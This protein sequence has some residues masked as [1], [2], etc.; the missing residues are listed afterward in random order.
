MDVV[1]NRTATFE[2]S[3]VAVRA[4]ELLHA[5]DYYRDKIKVLSLDCFDTILWRRTATPKDV[6]IDLQQQPT[7]KRLGLTNVMRVKG[8]MHAAQLKKITANHSHATLAEIHRACLLD[9]SEDEI[10]ALGEEEL[11]MEIASCYA[12]SPVV[13]LMRKAHHAGI[14]MIVVSDTYFEKNQLAQLLKSKLPDDVMNMIDAIFCSCEFGSTKTEGMFQPVLQQ[15]K[16]NPSAILHLGDNYN[17]DCIAPKSLGMHALHFSQHDHQVQ[18]IMRMQAVAASFFLQGV[19]NTQP[20]YNPFAGIFAEGVKQGLPEELI[21][22]ASIGPVMYVFA[23]F[24]FAEVE[25]LKQAGKRVKVVFML[26]DGYL[27]SLVCQ[28][29]QHAAFGELIEVSRF[30]AVAASF[31]SEQDVFDY[32]ARAM[33]SLR[34]KDM[35]RQLLLPKNIIESILEKLK[36]ARDPRSVF[37][38]FVKQPAIMKIILDNSTKYRARLK[39]YLQH[40]A[41]ITAGDTMVL[42]DLGYS[43][44]AQTAM[45]PSL[46]AEMN[47]DVVG[48]YLLAFQTH[49]QASVRKA[50]FNQEFY[51]SNALKMLVTYIS[52]FEQMCTSGGASVIDYDDAG[53]PIYSAADKIEK[54]MDKTRLI[55]SECVRFGLDAEKFFHSKAM[56]VSQAMLR[57][58]A[59]VALTRFVYLPTHTE[60]QYLDNFAHDINFGTDEVFPMAD[61]EL[62]L[63]QLRRRSWLFSL[64][65]QVKQM[66]MNYPAE[67]RAANL[68]LS[69][70]LMAQHRFDLEFAPT[71]LNCRRQTLNIVMKENNQMYQVPLEA[72]MTHDGFYSMIVPITPQNEV[73]IRFGL[74]YKWVE[75]ESADIIKL[76]YL[77][78]LSEASHTESVG[79][80]ELSAIQMTNHGGHLYECS[81]DASLLVFTPPKKIVSQEF[82][83][84]VVFRPVVLRE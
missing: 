69:F 40:K 33:M 57:D 83:L 36:E 43:C 58:A 39:K 47:V 13:D 71:D 15:L 60:I 63:Q 70:V 74:A 67:F 2:S 38:E 65:E 68:E 81:S 11:A 37:A 25:R 53:K 35:C 73:G 77:Y 54:Q 14:K 50:L 32:I 1:A 75:L 29:L 64:K 5:F 44:T 84:R 23:Q 42:V 18:E 9:I 21:G 28:A 3:R 6:F 22:Y 52:Q 4:H 48:L 80:E 46:Q 16:L 61:L 51:D 26:R 72:V 34:F 31:R 59:A 55:Q 76:K 30:A 8:E 27:P 62:G 45:T 7:F 66:R 10:R 49:D 79:A 56:T 82:V 19:R 20:H 24:I 78:S 41:G 17:A 12:F